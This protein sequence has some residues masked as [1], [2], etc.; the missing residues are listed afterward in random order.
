MK[1]VGSKRLR[2]VRILLR[3]GL[4]VAGFLVFRMVRRRLNLK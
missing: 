1:L 4:A 3:V 2:L